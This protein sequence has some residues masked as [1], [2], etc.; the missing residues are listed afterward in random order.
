MPEKKQQDTESEVNRQGPPFNEETEWRVAKQAMAN[1]AQA[2][3][4]TGGFA[5]SFE[6]AQVQ[7]S[8]V[9]AFIEKNKP[10]SMRKKPPPAGKKKPPVKPKGKA[11]AKGRKPRK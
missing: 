9:D 8:N 10:E 2:I 1:L 5:L 11:R 4:K 6:V 7:I 3:A